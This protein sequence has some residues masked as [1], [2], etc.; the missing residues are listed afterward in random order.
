MEGYQVD[1]GHYIRG[2]QFVSPCCGNIVRCRICHDDNYL[3]HELNRYK[4]NEIVCNKCSL[5]QIVSNNCIG[6]GIEFGKYFCNHCRLYE[7][8]ANRNIY[9]CDKCGLCRIGEVNDFFHCD[10]CGICLSIKLKDNHICKV[11]L[12]QNDCMICA[13][14]LFTSTKSAIILPCNH[15]IHTPCVNEWMKRN[16]GCPLCRK[17]MIT[18]E[19][20][21][22]YIKNYDNFISNNPLSDLDLVNAYCNDCNRNFQLNFHPFGLKCINCGGY[23][24]KL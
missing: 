11:N 15:V 3:D 13:Q 7:C 24:T 8:N 9:H 22:E 14:D 19:I 10:K 6:C 17:T 2:C 21:D 16:I 12:M 18:G 5:H 1:C 23:N 20:L 4:V